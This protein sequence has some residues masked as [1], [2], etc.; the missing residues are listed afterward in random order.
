VWAQILLGLS[1]LAELGFAAHVA[2]VRLRAGPFT[3]G[4]MTTVLIVD[5]SKLARI[6]LKKAVGALKPDWSL[7]EAASAEDALFELGRQAVDLAIVDFNMPGRNGLEL[8]EDIRR[9]GG[10][11]PIALVTANIQDGIIARARAL[12]VA[13]VAKPVTEDK[14]RGFV[15]GADISLRRNA[16]S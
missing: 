2:A 7:C 9:D 10:T 16:A 14:L 13:F 15:S 8:A 11:M 6:V 12:N 3:G 4:T 1:F 5:D